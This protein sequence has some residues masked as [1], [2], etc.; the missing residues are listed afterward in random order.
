[1]VA[2]D[3]SLDKVNSSVETLLGQIFHSSEGMYGDIDAS[4]H[5]ERLIAVLAHSQGSTRGRKNYKK[6]LRHMNN[7]GIENSQILRDQRPL[8]FSL[9]GMGMGISVIVHLLLFALFMILLFFI[10]NVPMLY[11][12]QRNIARKGVGRLLAR[13]V[14]PVTTPISPSSIQSIIVRGE[15][16]RYYEEI[17]SNSDGSFERNNHECIMT[18]VYMV[19][20]LVVVFIVLYLVSEYK[21]YNKVEWFRMFVYIIVVLVLFGAF[22]AMLFLTI[23]TKYNPMSEVEEQQLFL[24]S[25][26]KKLREPIRDLYS[27]QSEYDKDHALYYSPLMVNIIKPMLDARLS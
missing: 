25:L 6:L 16:D 21:M 15:V 9:E 12:S 23:I 18:A 4:K 8:G 22:E 14:D 26:G 11:S 19:I 24:D 20:A 1:M 10:V 7:V 2:T 3:M 13:Y 5:F 27:S 17:D